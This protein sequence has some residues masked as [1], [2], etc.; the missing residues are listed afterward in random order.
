[1]TFKNNAFYFSNIIMSKL[2]YF[3]LKNDLTVATVSFIIHFSAELS[4][5]VVQKKKGKRASKSNPVTASMN[6]ID[7]APISQQFKAPVDPKVPGADAIWVSLQPS[8]PPLSE[9]FCGKH[10]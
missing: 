10:S 3:K 5:V 2:H 4:L 7:P 1:M 6:P 9:H 8:A